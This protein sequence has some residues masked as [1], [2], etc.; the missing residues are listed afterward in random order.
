MIADHEVTAGDCAL[1]APL[2]AVN[3]SVTEVNLSNNVIGDDGAIALASMLK[4]N[5]TIVDVK[6]QRNYIY[7]KVNLLSGV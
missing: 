6:L 3:T 4:R 2:L 5:T 1:M 7:G